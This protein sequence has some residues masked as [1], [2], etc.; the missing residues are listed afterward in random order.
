MDKA[1]NLRRRAI[2]FSK[3]NNNKRRHMNYKQ[4]KGYKLFVL[5]AAISGGGD[6]KFSEKS[7]KGKVK[8]LSAIGKALSNCQIGYHVSEKDEQAQN[9]NT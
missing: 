6:L 3:P 2:R 5:K 9:T 8:S 4:F 1:R 7:K